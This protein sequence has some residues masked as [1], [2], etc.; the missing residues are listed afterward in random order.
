MQKEPASGAKSEAG[1][2]I[3]IYYLMNESNGKP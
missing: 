3:I 2:S 1:F